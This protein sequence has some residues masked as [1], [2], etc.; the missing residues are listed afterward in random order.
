MDV[1]C[2]AKLGHGKTAV[3]M[4]AMLQQLEPVDREVSIIILCHTRQDSCPELLCD[5]NGCPLIIVATPYWLNALVGD[6]V[7]DTKNV[8][9]FTL[10]ECDKML[11]QLSQSQAT[12]NVFACPHII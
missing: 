3:F 6:K 9:H 2:Q 11:E 10:D 5:K 7:L 1:L 4:L 12:S 8:K